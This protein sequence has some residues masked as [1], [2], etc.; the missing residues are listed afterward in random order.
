VAE[1][2]ALLY[3][4]GHPREQLERAL[5]VPSLSEGWKGS[6]RAL[7]AAGDQEG[8]AGLAQATPPPAWSGFR[9][10][11]VVEVQRE[12]DDILSLVMQAPDN[13]LLPV[14]LAGQFLV[15]RIDV[16]GSASPMLRSYSLSGPPGAGRYRISVKRKD[17]PGSQYFHDRVQPGDLLQVSAPRGSFTLS[18]CER[19]VVFLS[20][21]I[22]ATP[23]LS[24]LHGLATAGHPVPEIWWCYGARSGS[25]HPFATEVRDI[26]KGLPGG[27][28]FI[29]YS[30][31]GNQDRLGEDY[32]AVG[33]LTLTTL[34]QERAIPQTADFYLCGPA[35]FLQE[36]SDALK[37]WDVP[38]SRIHSETFGAGS[39]LTPGI[40][41]A[42]AAPPHPPAGE[43]GSGPT[44]SFTRTGL[45][46]PWNARFESLLELAEAC[47]VPVRWSCRV[48]VCHTCQ[49]GRIGGSVQ[50]S[51]T[52]LDPPSTSDVLICCATPLSEI[53]LDL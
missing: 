13:S 49:T 10:L 52:P 2:D 6:L 39:S 47:D 31:P 38:D 17:G 46:V 50:Y 16:E 29:V 37:A 35:A 22:G 12:C 32:D 24:M 53:E 40:A 41:G 30:R 26:L 36:L 20:V 15:F 14:P 51:P 23:V 11:R 34:R 42:P 45:T 1:V 21:G 9:P 48:G 28:S 27:H 44:I 3:L 33:H 8:N 43:P 19:P 5:R 25:E 7:L 18:A 4:P